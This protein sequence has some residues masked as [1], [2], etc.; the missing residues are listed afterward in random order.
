MKKLETLYGILFSALYQRSNQYISAICI[1]TF[2]LSFSLGI[3]QKSEARITP[4]GL[5]ITGVALGAAALGTAAY[6][7]YQIR[8][9]RRNNEY[10]YY[11]D[12]GYYYEQPRYAK[13]YNPYYD[14]DGSYY[15]DSDYYYEDDYYYY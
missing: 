12:D 3:S 10:Y 2:L 7:T 14:Y 6:N 4:K 1:C 13:R 5:A 11:E 15:N 9:D 8:K